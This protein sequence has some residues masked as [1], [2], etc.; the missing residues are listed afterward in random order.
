MKIA[1]FGAYGSFD[2]F[3]IGGTESFARRLAAGLQGQGCQ[4]DLVIYGSPASCRHTLASGAGC[5]YFGSLSRTLQFLQENHTHVVAIYVR[6][7]DRLVYARFRQANRGRLQFHQVLF[8]WPDSWLK[9]QAI[10]LEARL[11]S[12][13]GSLFCVSPRIYRRLSHYSRRAVLLLP[14]VPEDFFLKPSAKPKNDKIKI[15]Y[16]GRTEPGKGIEEVIELFTGLKDCPEV[17]LEIHGYHHA[18]SRTAAHFHRRLGRQKEVRYF[19]RPYDSY[20]P[21]LDQEVRRILKGTDIL[22][23][24]YRKLSSTIDTPLLLLEGMASLCAVA[25]RPFGDIPLIYGPGP[26]LFDGANGIAS[27]TGL[28]LAG[29]GMLQGERHRLWRRH[30]ALDYGAK[31]VAACFLRA[32]NP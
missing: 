32:I 25:T 9:R 26:F 30:R 27:L 15:T 28:L 23:L 16:I 5:F 22:V 6:P 31:A 4:A 8:S 20:N 7:P 19:H 21:G 18:S 3:R 13:N 1:F 24:P 12:V 29:K 11:F 14:P 10:F 17:E 2:H